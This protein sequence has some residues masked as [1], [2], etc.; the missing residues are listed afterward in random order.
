MFSKRVAHAIGHDDLAHGLTAQHV[1]QCSLPD[2]AWALKFIVLGCTLSLVFT[3]P[4]AVGLLGQGQM[5]NVV[6]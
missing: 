1:Q 4:A 3:M 2:I 5:G 6:M